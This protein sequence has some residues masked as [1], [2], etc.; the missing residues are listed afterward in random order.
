MNIYV[1]K[2]LKTVMPM[3]WKPAVDVSLGVR[4]V[5]KP[6]DIKVYKEFLS[7]TVPSTFGCQSLVGVLGI[8]KAEL[9]S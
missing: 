3:N 4:E 1:D 6:D 8:N 9:R 7:K 2:T 5:T